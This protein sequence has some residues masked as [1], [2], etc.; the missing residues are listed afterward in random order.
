MNGGTESREAV[1]RA[2]LL[3]FLFAL[4]LRLAL[5]F[6]L[7]EDVIW[8]DGRRYERVALSVLHG[9]GFGDIVQNRLSVPTQPLLIAGVYSVFGERNYLALRIVSAVLGATAVL[10]GF[11]LARSL[12]GRTAAICAGI[13]LA[14]YPYLAYLSAL[15]EYPQLLFIV[16][17]VGFFL[18]YDRFQRSKRL[19]AL[20]GA[21]VCLGI[22]VLTVPTALLFVPVLALLL[23]VRNPVESSRRIAVLAVGYSQLPRVRTGRPREFGERLEFLGG[24]QRHLRALR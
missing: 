13:M 11:L 10:L 12:F 9:E 4:V 15:F 16:L 17:M 8:P 24:Q 1:G 20:F 18:L 7:P 21:C 14:G 23:L 19:T 2:A 22:G 3:I 6:W 5:A